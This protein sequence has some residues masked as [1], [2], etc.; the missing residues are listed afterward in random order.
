MFTKFCRLFVWKN[1]GKSSSS[2]GLS[3]AQTFA[4]LPNYPNPFSPLGRG[5]FGNSE[6]KIRFE[7]PEASHV[8]VKIFNA[9]GAEVRTLA[10]EQREAGSHRV[11]WDGKD[12]HGR[13]VASGV[14]LYQLRVGPSTGSG[15]GFSQARRMNLL[16]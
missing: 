15:R 6:T 10:D 12:A 3:R 13:P 7:L 14:Y 5:T 11:R 16:R 8:V 9:L 4:L 1:F 2:E